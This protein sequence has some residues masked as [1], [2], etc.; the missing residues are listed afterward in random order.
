MYLAGGVEDGRIHV[1]RNGVDLDLFRPD[2]PELPL[3]APRGTRFLFV[4]G[5]IERKGPDLLLAAYL[6]AFQDRDD[7]SLIV[8]D[9]GAD[10]IYPGAD[11]TRLEAYA[12]ERTAP[13]TGHR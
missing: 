10:T 9:F 2:G 6:D 4:G 7:V 11:R 13:R 3:D 12:R 8:K 1:V 5:L